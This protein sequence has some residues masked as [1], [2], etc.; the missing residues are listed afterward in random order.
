MT[1]EKFTPVSLEEEI[2]YYL[3]IDLQLYIDSSD[4]EEKLPNYR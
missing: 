2:L 3:V 4:I 1:S